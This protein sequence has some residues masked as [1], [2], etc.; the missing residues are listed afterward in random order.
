LGEL[1]KTLTERLQKPVN[2][3]TRKELQSQCVHYF[4][5]DNYIKKLNNL[6]INELAN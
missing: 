3:T 2:E 4:N 6:L 1:E 5:E